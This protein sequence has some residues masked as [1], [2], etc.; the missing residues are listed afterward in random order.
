MSDLPELDPLPAHSRIDGEARAFLADLMRSH[1]QQGA[2]IRSLAA[3]TN[4]SYGWVVAMLK[5]SR[6]KFRPR[7]RR[8]GG[9]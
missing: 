8:A 7:G 3:Q 4:R 9:R 2:S 6:T 5:E 1:Y